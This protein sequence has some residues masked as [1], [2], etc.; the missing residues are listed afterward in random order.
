MRLDRPVLDLVDDIFLDLN[1]GPASGLDQ[2]GEGNGDIT[3]AVD[4]LV[5]NGHEIARPHACFER[6]EQAA[7]RRF[8]NRDRDNIADAE[9][10]VGRWAPVRERTRESFGFMGRENVDGLGGKLD[11]RIRDGRRSAAF[12]IQRRRSGD[13][14]ERAAAAPQQGEGEQGDQA[15]SQAQHEFSLP[16]TFIHS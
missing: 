11:Q 1:A 7:G 4:H 6:Y 15:A 13:R 14:K 9:G 3:V 2:S 12:N 16:K 5:R 10:D 8:E